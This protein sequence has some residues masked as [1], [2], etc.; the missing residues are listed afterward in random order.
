MIKTHN[1]DPEVAETSRIIAEI[2]GVHATP[3][4]WYTHG[5][6]EY[7]HICGALAWPTDEPGALVIAGVKRTD[8][9]TYQVIDAISGLNQ[10][11]NSRMSVVWIMDAARKLREK[12]QSNTKDL[13]Q[14]FWGDWGKFAG[15]LTDYNIDNKGDVYLS[16]PPDFDRPDAGLIY[17]R[18]LE[19]YLSGE[20]K[21]LYLDNPLVRSEIEKLIGLGLGKRRSVQD[22]SPMV[23]AL[24]FCVHS[25]RA[26][27]YWEANA[28][29]NFFIPTTGDDL[30]QTAHL[31]EI[32]L[33]ELF[34]VEE[35]GGD[36]DG[37]IP[38]I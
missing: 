17:W 10:G 11:D 28:S 36:A 25:L 16:P 33:R 18:T 38:T 37:V 8:P 20:N 21:K 30:A 9:A 32:A 35:T 27:R 22:F 13:L 24:G 15:L 3:E 19:S 12:Y 34:G 6:T 1:I 23:M 2:T 7:W 14:V 29:K 26:S 5:D 31:E 4:R